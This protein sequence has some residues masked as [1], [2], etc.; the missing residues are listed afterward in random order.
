[1]GSNKDLNLIPKKLRRFN[2]FM[3]I[4]LLL[5]IGGLTGCA[6]SARTQAPVIQPEML[7]VLQVKEAQYTFSMYPQFESESQ[8]RLKLDIRNDR[9]DFMHGA[10]VVADL[11]AKDGHQ[12][13]AIFTEDIRLEKY[14]ARIPLNHHEDYVITTQIQ[15][16]DLVPSTFKPR[17]FFHCCDPI[18][19][20]M[21]QD[22]SIEQQRGSPK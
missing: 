17:F 19:E 2:R 11:Q 16:K 21:D 7:P 10:Q 18:P 13:K 5:F 14:V 4:F 22:T 6:N 15:L 9:G 8:S 3:R 1:M 12:Q 20:L